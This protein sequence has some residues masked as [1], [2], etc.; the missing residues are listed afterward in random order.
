LRRD[1]SQDSTLHGA[2]FAR[3]N[4]DGFGQVMFENRLAPVRDQCSTPPI[5]QS[6]LLTLSSLSTQRWT[7]LISRDVDRFQSRPAFSQAA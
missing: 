2:R 3:R 4:W 7:A 1:H 5:P 6:R